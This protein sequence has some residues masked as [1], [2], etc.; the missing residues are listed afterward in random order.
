MSGA[1][2]R[3][4]GRPERAGRR[5]RAGWRRWRGCSLPRPARGGDAGAATV[6][7]LALAG[8]LAV[9]GA[10]V[11]GATQAVA[12]RHRAGSAADL[13]ALAAAARWD[14]GERQACARAARVAAAQ[15][16]RVSRCH[17]L[18]EVVEV[19]AEVP[20]PGWLAR[21]RPVGVTAR[22]GP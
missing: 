4:S 14:E 9:T 2:P 12:A 13:A 7:V 18:G 8:I 1:S 6:L 5:D 20:L 21:V 3:P 19:T 15:G 10:T 17:R 22:A 11:L 16:A